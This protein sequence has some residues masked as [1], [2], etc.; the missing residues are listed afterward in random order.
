M[1][2]VY[3]SAFPII[4]I[5]NNQT[6]SFSFVCEVKVSATHYIIQHKINSNNNIIISFRAKKLLK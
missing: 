6:F 2:L 4:I 5:A 3:C 1:L